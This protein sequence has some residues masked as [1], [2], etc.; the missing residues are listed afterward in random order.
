MTAALV[1]GQSGDSFRQRIG[2]A[3][4]HHETVHSLG[5]D[6]RAGRMRGGNDRQAGR[7]RLCD[8]HAKAFDN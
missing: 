1:L 2:A 3:N 8:H 7:E 5:E 4:R 6:V